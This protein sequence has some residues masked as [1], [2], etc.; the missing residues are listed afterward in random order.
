MYDHNLN[1][2]IVPVPPNGQDNGAPFPEKT[3]ERTLHLIDTAALV[4]KVNADLVRNAK[5]EFAA[6]MAEL[7]ASRNRDG[8]TQPENTLA[9]EDE[10]NLNQSETKAGL[11]GEA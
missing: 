7:N 11:T 10:A 2:R 8:S 4:R 5:A 3:L 6:V 9:E 1:K